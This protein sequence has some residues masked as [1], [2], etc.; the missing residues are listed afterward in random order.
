MAPMNTLEPMAFVHFK[1]WMSALP[2]RDPLKRRRDALQA[3][4]V[5]K[6]VREYLPNWAK[7]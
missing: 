3:E 2:G 6:A 5:E 1:Q 4:R 7:D